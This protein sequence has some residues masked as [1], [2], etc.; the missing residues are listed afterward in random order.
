MRPPFS[1]FLALRYLQPKRTFVSVI[2]LISIL[3]VVLGVA[4]LLVVIS[5]MTGFGRELQ[6]KV[7]GFEAHIMVTNDALMRD[8]RGL[9]ELIRAV[10]DVEATSPYVQGA[11]II[12]Y[13]GRIH[14]PKVRAVEIERE[15]EMADLANMIRFGTAEISSDQCLI[16]HDLAR[17]L[18]V[19][20]GDKITVYAPR[21]IGTLIELLDRLREKRDEQTLEQLR[22]VVLPAELEVTG[23]FETGRYAYDAE[24][25]ITP[26]HIGQELYGLEDEIHGIGVRCRDPY[27]LDRIF[28]AIDPLLPDGVIALSW[29]D[30]NQQL[31]DAI[32]LERNTMFVLL[33]IIVIVAGFGIMN[34]LIT[35]T[36]QKRREI[37]VLKAL[38][39]R[40]GQIVQ[41][42]LIQGIIVGFIGTVLGLGLGLLTVQYRNQFKEWLAARLGIEIFPARVYQFT[43]IPAEIVPGDVAVMCLSAFVICALA[44]LLPAWTAARLDPVKALRYE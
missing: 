5:V 16:G 9:E 26:L 40:P 39:A 25:V 30:M 38:G 21:N 19:L 32:R 14:T 18:G 2:T 15:L 34:T 6:R 11:V 4:A 31:F 1:F 22:E 33:T 10:P 7:L 42:F 44:A 28:A 35:V 43:E 17:Q 27:A 29:M 8:W 3:G 12:E 36:V 41:V 13:A 24:F 23:I 20:V 37:G